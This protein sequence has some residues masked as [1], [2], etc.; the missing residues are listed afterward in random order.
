MLPRLLQSHRPTLTRLK[1]S[2]QRAKR[3]KKHDAKETRDEG[4]EIEIEIDD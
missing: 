2:C 3:I 4:L 1:S